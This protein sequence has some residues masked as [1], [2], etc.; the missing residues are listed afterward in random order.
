MQPDSRINAKVS[1]ETWED[2]S[3]LPFNIIRSYF[4]TELNQPFFPV[5]EQFIEDQYHVDL[6]PINQVVDF[7]HDGFYAAL[8]IL[9]PNRMEAER[10][11][12]R[13]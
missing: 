13:T 11:A 2:A 10:T 7:L 1:S 6:I 3:E 12:E 9:V 8:P 5:T 4:V